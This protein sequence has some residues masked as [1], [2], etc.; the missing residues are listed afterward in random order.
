MKLRFKD[1]SIRFR[2]TQSD[3]TQLIDTG[4]VEKTIYFAPDENLKMTYAL[5]HHPSAT[6]ASVRY[7]ASHLKVVLPTAD[8]RTWGPSDQVGI[9]ATVDLG[10]H[11]NLE[12]L[13]EKDYACLDLSDADN[14][15]TFP[16]PGICAVSQ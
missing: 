13:V 8:V 4:R 3:L 16:N 14:H 10:M 9:Y 11:G 2:V 12:I 5:E 15:D 1:N 7:H 6:C